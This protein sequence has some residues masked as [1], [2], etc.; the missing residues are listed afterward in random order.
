[1][2]LD[3]ETA[4]KTLSRSAQVTLLVF[5]F[6]YCQGRTT[7]LSR[8]TAMLSGLAVLA[9]AN[10][11]SWAA[12]EAA[13][14]EKPESAT[15]LRVERRSIEVNGKPASVLGIRQPDG[16]PG[17]VTS[18][19][20]QFRVRLENQLDAPTL[21]HWHGLTPPWRQDGVPGVSGPPIPP[22]GSAEYDFPL[23][24]GGTFW[25]HSHQGL[26]EQE[27]LAAPLIIRDERDQA[28]QK[29]V[30]IMLADFSF[31]P[32]E[33][34]FAGLRKGAGMRAVATAGPKPDAMAGT[35]ASPV[36]TE[37]AK[38]AMT[39]MAKVSAA[40]GPDLNDVK[41]DA[42]LANDRTLADPEVIRVEPGGHVLLRVINSSS[43]SAFHLDLGA[44][45]GELIAVDGFRVEPVA[46][47]RFPIAVAQRLDIRIAIP[48]GPAAYPALAILEGQRNQT[49][50]I[51]LAGDT[52]VS[53]V[54]ELAEMKS[55]ALT[56]D[57]ERRLRAVKPLASRK[58]DRV[59]ELN[60]TGAMERYVW[61]ING[62]PWNESVPPLPIAEGERVE[63][64]LDNK[65]PMPHP[66]HLHGHE[67]QV[68]EI[69]GVRFAGPVRDTV[70]VPP[71]TRVVVAFDANNPGWWAFHCHLLYHLDAGMFTTLRYL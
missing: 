40:A 64:V 58:A 6:A 52:R 5:V 29:E 41:Y 69:N 51:L 45:D 42:F 37:S 7:M 48:Q 4:V 71:E 1:L 16:A 20:K 39:S 3:I 28:D 30:V 38:S 21:I 49:G 54:P 32:P 57:L 11:R 36:K 70:L 61:S 59:H 50:V 53:R 12:P 27:L 14:G 10:Q 62:V 55:A 66:M 13:V 2:R 19:G 24:F 60:L 68:V 35:E 46:G 26:Q 34:I 33:Q 25:M 56:L 31:T 15:V 22:G 18:V 47:R 9:T 67:F 63:L 44:L 8:R 17:L 43:M 23:R 65:T